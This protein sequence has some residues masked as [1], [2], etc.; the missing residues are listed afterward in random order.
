MKL[1]FIKFMKYLLNLN[2]SLFDWIFFYILCMWSLRNF[3]N[4]LLISIFKFNSIFRFSN[5]KSSDKINS[6][7]ILN[8]IL[9]SSESFS[10]AIA[11][12]IVSKNTRSKSNSKKRSKFKSSKLVLVKPED[13]EN[14][15]NWIVIT[16]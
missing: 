11:D 10:N 3:Y 16:V 12:L 15:E 1:F 6:I 2:S 5:W 14:F 7:I 8:V 13:F 4:Q 9:S